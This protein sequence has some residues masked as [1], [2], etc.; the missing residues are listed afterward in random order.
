MPNTAL[1]ALANR[2]ARV[3][4]IILDDD[5]ADM[6]DFGVIVRRNGETRVCGLDSQSPA[7][8]RTLVEAAMIESKRV[9]AINAGWIE[10]IPDPLAYYR[11]GLRTFNFGKDEWAPQ[12][13]EVSSGKWHAR[14]TVATGEN[15]ERR[16]TNRPARP[17]EAPMKRIPLEY[18]TMEEAMA[19][20]LAS[21]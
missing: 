3:C 14:R 2:L 15:W 19:A 6:A 5:D 4:Q 11:N 16:R 8:L 17:D 18:A 9:D 1:K 7:D 10:V 13:C 12:V 21:D 20:A